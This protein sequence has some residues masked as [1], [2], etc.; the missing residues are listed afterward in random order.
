MIT[1]SVMSTQPLHISQE[2]ARRFLATY[3]FTTT[4]LPGVFDRL[5]TVQY[6]PL[7]P[8]GRNPDL[9]FQ[10]RVPGYRVDD[11]QEAA[12]TDRIVYDAWD[13]QACLVPVSD[14]PR[15]AYGRLHHRT[16]HDREILQSVPDIVEM[17]LTAIETQGPLS[18]LEFEQ[19]EHT[20]HAF[21][22]TEH[23][24]YGQT[25]IKRV[26]RSLWACSMLLTHHRKNG[27][28]YYDL[29]ERVIPQR[30][31]AAPPL[32]DKDAY[33]RWI[34]ARRCQAIGLLRPAAEA[35]IW[36][37]CGDATTRRCI[38][39][40][41]VA[42]GTLTPVAVGAKQ[43]LAYMP[44][45]ALPLL[46]AAPPSPRLI[47]LGP[48]DSILWDRKAIQQIFGFDYAWEVYKPPAQRRWGYYVLPVF[49]ADRL[50]ARIDSRLEQGTW[51]IARWWWEP[52]VTPDAELLE[53]LSKAAAQFLHYLRAD[54]VVVD[55]SVDRA[56]AQAFTAIS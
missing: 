35:A 20:S 4:D 27:R 36:S 31:Y 5:G 48:L 8:V 10:A 52:D 15:R 18:S 38:L 47:F 14:W 19:P 37:A 43:W 24:W 7:N 55:E 42:E 46:D 17:I 34:I 26:L 44:T 30:H 49:Y 1:E 50:V 33:Y 16:Y 9:V 53:A 23:S 12:Y 11:W 45:S 25:L 56:A 39:A 13:K 51:K 22:R 54:S 29:P 21:S 3:H 32:L 2:Q 41:L 6:D 28:H 40:Q